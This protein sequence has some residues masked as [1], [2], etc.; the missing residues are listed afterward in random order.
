MSNNCKNLSQSLFIFCQP[1]PNYDEMF[2]E[3]FGYGKEK[4]IKFYDNAVDFLF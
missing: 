1:H 2:L 4:T 3:F